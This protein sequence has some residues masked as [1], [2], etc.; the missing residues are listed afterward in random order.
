MNFMKKYWYILFG[1]FAFAILCFHTLVVYKNRGNR[2]REQV[3]ANFFFHG[4]VVM[5]I[6]TLFVG[7]L[8]LLNEPSNSLLVRSAPQICFFLTGIYA[9]YCHAKWREEHHISQNV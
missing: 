6:P 2:T 1:N 4:M 9:T 7:L 3:Y 5:G 8:T